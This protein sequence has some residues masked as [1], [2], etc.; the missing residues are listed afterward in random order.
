MKILSY[1]GK[2]LLGDV[3]PTVAPLPVKIEPIPVSRPVRPS[4]P[5]RFDAAKCIDELTSGLE[6]MARRWG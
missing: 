6:A 4:A 1:I 3:T 2:V 5:M